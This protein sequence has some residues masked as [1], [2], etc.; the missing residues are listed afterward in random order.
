MVSKFEGIDVSKHQGTIDWQKV[1]ETGKVQFAILRAGYGRYYPSQVDQTFEYNYQQ[2]KKLNIPV[3]AYW[4]SYAT[5][6]DE[7]KQEMAC[8]LKT[9]QGKSFEFPLYF[10]QEYEPG[11]VAL[12]NEV[13]T[14]IVK[15][16]L[17]ELKKAGYTAGLYCSADW[18]NNKLNYSSLTN[19]ELWIAQYSS[20]CTS[21]L[22]YGMWQYSSSGSIS[23]ITGNVDLNHCYKDYPSIIGQN[24]ENGNSENQVIESDDYV[25]DWPL[26]GSHIITAGYYY[27]GGSLHRAIDFRVEYKQPVLAAGD[28]VVNFTYTWNGKI[29]SGDTNS[30]GN[31]VKILHDKKYNNGNVETLYAHLDSYIVKN[32]QRVKAGDIIGYAGYTGNVS[33]AGYNGKHLHFEVRYLGVRRN[34]LAWLD[35]DFTTANS[36]VYTF[37]EGE[38]SA[39]RSTSGSSSGSGSSSTTPS[40]PQ[41]P[42]ANQKAITFKNGTWNVR[43]GPGTNYASIGTIKSPGADGKSVTI[44]YTD[45]VDGWYK[46]IYGYV[47][48][49]AIEEKEVQ[50]AIT[51]NNG[52]WNVRKGPGTNY[53]SV[54]TIVSPA[55][56]KDVTIGYESVTNNWYKTIYGYIGPAAIKSHT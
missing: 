29:T 34:P 44:G 46:T 55:N 22:P 36:S 13:R 43:K 47:G 50:K 48:P 8:F 15:A 12:S 1:K 54:G 26:T 20:S 5:N 24:G 49:A 2:A 7:V 32:G 16:A 14:D 56:G 18:I 25:L 9:V 11:I 27:S 31:C 53:A 30:Y 21:K 45:I 35:S 23:G 38:R 37:G 42:T 28:G 39:I 19:C 4:Y 3:G 10:D 6:V 51:L 17:E 33:P 52:T 41:T 40:T